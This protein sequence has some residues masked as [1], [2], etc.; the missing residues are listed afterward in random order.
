MI[1]ESSKRGL[2]VIASMETAEKSGDERRIRYSEQRHGK[3]K[4]K[5]KRWGSRDFKR[6]KQRMNVSV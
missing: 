1:E 4:E 2:L 6:V 5:G 3:G